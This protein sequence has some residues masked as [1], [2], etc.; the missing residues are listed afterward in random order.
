MNRTEQIWKEYH[1]KL[2]RFI[3]MRIGSA[4]IADD[5]FQEVFI[6]IHA[7]IGSLKDN[8]KIESWIYQITRNAIIDHY[9]AHKIM[10]Q[11]PEAISAPEPNTDGG[12]RR[13]IVACLLPMIKGLPDHYREAVMLSEIEGVTQKE[14]AAK[15][16][17]SL[18]G[19][20]SRI[21][22]GRLLLKEMLLDCCHFEFDRRGKVIDYKRKGNTCDK[23]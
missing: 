5:I 9:R 22:R 2:H 21:Q 13:E 8:N 15:H 23:C 11:L 7:R 19:A 4:S 12:A 20:K 17:L 16:A 3:Q 14:V 1:D 6:R 18:S 10:E